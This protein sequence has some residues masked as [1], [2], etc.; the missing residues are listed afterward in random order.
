[1][2]LHT[3]YYVD[4]KVEA[5]PDA[6]T[7]LMFVRGL[8]RAGEVGREGFIPAE[9]LPKLARRRRYAAS[10][11]ALLAAGLWTSVPGGYQVTSWDHWQ[12]GLD[13]LTRRRT[14]DRE[15]QRRRRA[16]EREPTRLSR[17]NE[18]PSRDK[19]RDVTVAEGEE[20]LEGVQVGD[21]GHGYPRA[22]GEPP[23][24]CPQHLHNPKPP[25]CG[26]CA[27][28]RRTHSRW[29][30]DHANRTQDAPKCPRHAGQLADH[31]RACRS[32]Q[33]AGTD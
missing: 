33:I 24:Q 32:E 10:V 9:S 26:P 14:A 7:E 18:H 27:D 13:A 30:A 20:D 21:L 6:D 3:R 16:A 19:S 8:A 15:R 5:L 17:D 23:R 1:M 25:P 22:R 11:E 12:D 29:Q 28:T 2:K 31:C 4:A